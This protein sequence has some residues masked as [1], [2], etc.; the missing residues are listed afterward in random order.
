MLGSGIYPEGNRAEWFQ[1]ME[2]PS[3][4]RDLEDICQQQCVRSLSAA[5]GQGVPIIQDLM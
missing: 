4:A 3:H 5:Q 2:E 1:A